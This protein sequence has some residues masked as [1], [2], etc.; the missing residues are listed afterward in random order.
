MTLLLLV[1]QTRGARSPLLFLINYLAPPI[2]ISR[3]LGKAFY[4]PIHGRPFGA[5]FVLEVLR[6]MSA[7][8][9][10]QARNLLPAIAGRAYLGD[11]GT[12]NPAL[13][14]MIFLL[15]LPQMRRLPEV[16]GLRLLVP[17]DW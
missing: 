9:I 2:R 8:L 6:R 14:R 4:Q 7:S 15:L 5:Y 12:A 13:L 16:G 1:N 11:L 17:E 3:L 10:L